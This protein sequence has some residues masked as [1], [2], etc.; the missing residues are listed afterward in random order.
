MLYKMAISLCRCLL[1]I[2]EQIWI[3]SKEND[4]YNV[5]HNQINKWI[6]S[7]CKI[8]SNIS[9][10]KQIWCLTP[11]STIVKLY[12]GGQFYWWGKPEYPAKTTDKYVNIYIY[13][14]SMKI[15]IY[16]HKVCKYINIYTN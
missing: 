11:H 5:Y 4:N 3:T 15:Y 7:T 12:R 10:L 2:E 16:L 14:Q 6:T 8:L 13:T 9:A 1:D